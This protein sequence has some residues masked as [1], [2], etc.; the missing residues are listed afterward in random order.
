MEFGKVAPSE[1]RKIDFTLP[2]DK[3]GTS[4]VL[5]KSKSR[6]KVYVGCAKWG[7][8]DWIGKI[9]PKGTKESDFL[10]H[11][12]RHFSAI[13]LNALFYRIFDRTVIE[14]WAQKTAPGFKFCPKF[15]GAITHQ[16]RLK[17]AR[18]ITNTYLGSIHSF[19]SKLGPCFIQ[20][21]DNFPPKNIGDIDDYLGSLPEDLEVFVEVRHPD[22][23]APDTLEELAGVLEKHKAGF[24]ITDAS[25][26]RDCVHMRLTTPKAFIRFV[27]N[28]LHATD[29]TRVDDWVD[30]IRSWMK[31]G[32]DE[33]YFFMHQHEELHSP[34]LCK[35]TIQQLNS[36]CG[37]KI[38]EPQ[39]V[40]NK[41][42]GLFN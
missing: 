28:G 30:R 37:T 40:T 1:L 21:S 22:W 15:N 27:G 11:Y 14:K 19:G 34:E 39:F 26:R 36:K 17:N 5:K 16:K 12:A 20:L 7:R 2:P 6:P 8:K 31:K 29:Y 35:Y 23:F 41:E 42:K 9:Y 10:E 13:E 33:V 32:I 4:A 3:K 38:P 24:V 25:G 18:E